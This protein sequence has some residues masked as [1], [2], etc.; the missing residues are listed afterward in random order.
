MSILQHW[1]DSQK[2]VKASGTIRCPKNYV[3]KEGHQP[4]K[5]VPNKLAKSMTQAQLDDLNKRFGTNIKRYTYAKDKYGNKIQDFNNYYQPL[6]SKAYLIEHV[7][8]PLNPICARQ[9]RGRC[10]KGIGNPNISAIK[11]LNG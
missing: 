6:V 8:D 9:C 4:F 7:Y 1:H 10:L 3:L 5:I 11:R 2:G